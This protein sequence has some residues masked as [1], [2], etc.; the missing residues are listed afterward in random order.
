MKPWG[1]GMGQG[2]LLSPWPWGKADLPAPCRAS[3]GPQMGGWPCSGAKAVLA[4]S[5][6]ASLF[7]SRPGDGS[8]RFGF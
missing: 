4:C 2:R 3:R 1:L 5:P 7:S 8:H 6:G